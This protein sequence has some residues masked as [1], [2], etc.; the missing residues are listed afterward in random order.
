MVTVT[1]RSLAA[2]ALSRHYEPM[3]VD[4]WSRATSS[5]ENWP[6]FPDNVPGWYMNDDQWLTTPEKFLVLIAFKKWCC[7]HMCAHTVLVW[8]PRESSHALNSSILT[9]IIS[10]THLSESVGEWADSILSNTSPGKQ[11]RQTR[12]CIRRRYQVLLWTSST[13]DRKS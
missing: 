5:Q 3:L 7:I 12:S 13:I 11:D 2:C 6:S 8:L 1:W 4:S 10:P 9:F